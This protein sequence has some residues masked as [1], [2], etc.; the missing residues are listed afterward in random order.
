MPRLTWTLALTLA[1]LAL[2]TRVAAFGGGIVPLLNELSG[3]LT[4][5]PECTQLDPDDFVEPGGTYTAP[6]DASGTLLFQCCIHPWM[7]TVVH[8]THR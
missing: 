3:N 4:V 1:P 8:A 7:R 5:A 2:A 6:I